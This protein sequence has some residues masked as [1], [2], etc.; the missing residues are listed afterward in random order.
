M[1]CVHFSASERTPATALQEGHIRVKLRYLNQTQ[2]VVQARPDDT[3][4]EFKQ[5]EF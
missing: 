2:T 4:A 3:I 1:E 5:L